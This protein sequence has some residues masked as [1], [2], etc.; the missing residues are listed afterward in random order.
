[1]KNML[2]IIGAVL[3]SGAFLIVIFAGMAGQLFTK[4]GRTNRMPA[5]ST[6]ARP[7]LVMA[8]SGYI[9]L[10]ASDEQGKTIDFKTMNGRMGERPGSGGAACPDRTYVYELRDMKIWKKAW[11]IDAVI[12]MLTSQISPILEAC[13]VPAGTD[14]TC[15]DGCSA[16]GDDEIIVAKPLSIVM[17][18]ANVAGP[19]ILQ[20]VL[21]ANGACIRVMECK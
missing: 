8:D 10:I 16:R 12:S 9:D 18:S 20:F 1:M 7:G 11:G 19:G 3:A 2:N 15:G 4:S 13:A 17:N 14:F 21:T 5:Y 6:S